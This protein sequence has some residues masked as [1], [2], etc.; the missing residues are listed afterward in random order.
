[1]NTFFNILRKT[2]VAITVVVFAFVVVYVPQQ[3][4]KAE[5]IPVTIM[6]GPGS[7][8]AGIAAGA[9]VGVLKKETLLD[10]I[11][12]LLA[13]TM[14]SNILQS[15]V[16]WINSGFKGSPA[17]IQDIEQFLLD[18]A[19]EAA[20]EYIRSLGEVGSFICSPFRLDIQLALA[21]KYQR[22]REGRRDENTCTLSGVVDNLERFYE[23]QID[24]K[25]FWDQWIRITSRPTA[26]TPYGQF[27]AAEGQLDAKL[28]NARGQELQLANWGNGF[29][30]NKICEA[31]EGSNGKNKRCVIS[32][33]G[34]V[35]AEQLNNTLDT[36]R[37][38]LVAADEINEVISALLGQ[39]AN[40]AL[41][42]AA[43][44]LGLSRGTGFT[45]GGFAEGS[46]VDELATQ[47]RRNGESFI[48]VGYQETV[49][50]L[51]VQEELGALSTEYVPKLLEIMNAPATAPRFRNLTETQIRDL[52]DRAEIARADAIEV[53]KN[54][55]EHILALTPV[56]RR[57][58]ALQKE[59]NDPATTKER[60]QQ[61]SSEQSELI[62]QAGT[63][64]AYTELRLR[65][66]RRE[67][68]SIVGS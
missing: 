65:D 50:K 45:A 12:F 22:A 64:S 48:E 21:L 1:M 9:T 33:P 16:R 55:A 56:V 36:G 8:A 3:P 23:N 39:I 47:N 41:I 67:W 29:L 53:Q 62:T 37:Q 35:I 57:L 24:R 10:Q 66:S 42:G 14:I 11:A 18:V 46:Y 52:K 30:S 60:K 2:L 25:N 19:D 63:Y 28:V 5:A 20:G 7:I 49:D 34:R 32:T 27:I 58:D 38:Q 68:T 51:R 44:L 43:G 54:T 40:Q 17:F 13:R 59:Y 4:K 15:T 26:Y 61:I 31:I 6:G